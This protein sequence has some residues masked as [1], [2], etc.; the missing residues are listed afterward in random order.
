[1][2]PFIHQNGLHPLFQCL[3]QM[4]QFVFE[5]TIS[6]LSILWLIVINTR[7]LRQRTFLRTLHGGEK[8]TK[9]DLRQA[10]QPLLLSPK[11]RE[12]LTVNTHKGLFQ[13]T[14]LQFGV[15]SASGIFQR[16]LKNR[17]VSIPFVK[18]RSDDI[19]V[20]GKNDQGH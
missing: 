1:M 14:R 11:L 19:L 18:V 4:A 10:Y 6:R 16:E 8:F 9:L 7:F 17:L 15:D 2:S 13:P 5:G 20:S 12:L 3:S